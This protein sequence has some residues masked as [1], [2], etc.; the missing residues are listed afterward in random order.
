MKTKKVTA[1]IEASS[2]GF[3]IFSDDLPG[4]TGYGLTIEE[5]KKDIES[6]I[7]DVLES[8][9]EEGDKAPAW[10]NEGKLSFEYKYDMASLFKHF[11]IFD[12][13]ALAK[14]IGI[15]PSLMRQ[16]KAGITTSISRKQKEK[17]EAGL[18]EVGRSLLNIKL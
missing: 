11:A 14:R 17:I 5:A 1:V 10:L 4:I 16:Y 12:V 15:N 8:Y 13:S 7:E 3:G 9:Q 6:A 18:H 2:T